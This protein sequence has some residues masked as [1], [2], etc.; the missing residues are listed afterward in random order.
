MDFRFTAALDWRATDAHTLLRAYADRFGPGDA[1]TLL[2][3]GGSV[4]SVAPAAEALGDGSPDMVLVEHVDASE[5]APRIDAVLGSAAPGDV[6]CLDAAGL[7]ALFDLRAPGVRRA[8]R[9]TCNLCGTD[10]VAETRGW[11]RDTATC[12]RCGS[13]ARFRGLAD[14]IARDLFGSPEPLHALPPRPDLTGVG[15]SDPLPLAALLGRRMAYANT[16]YHCEPR[17]DVCAPGDHA[18]RYDLVVCSEVL[19]HVPDW[20]AALANVVAMA[21]RYVV[22]TVPGGKRRRMDALVGHHRHFVPGQIAA[23]LR[24]EGCDPVWGHRWGWPVHSLYRWGISRAGA[25]RMY[26]SFGTERY[27]SVQI[28][29]SNV[30]Y[31]AFFVNDVFHRGDQIMVLGAK[32]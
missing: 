6:P 18:G 2:I 20:R 14:L 17:L 25:D 29:L 19:E 27:S 24:E 9:F 7:R 22:I 12:P 32:R 15:M 30:L 8:H 10:A 3:H 13:A 5:L 11:P 31:G 28:G 1:A 26:R 4:E 21:R 23:A 16:Y